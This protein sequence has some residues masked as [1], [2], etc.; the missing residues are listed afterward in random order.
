MNIYLL[1]LKEDLEPNGD[2]STKFF[3]TKILKA[4]IIA[5]EAGV[6]AC[7]KLI[8]ELLK[9]YKEFSKKT[10]VEEIKFFKKDGEDFSDGEILVEIIAPSDALLICERSILNFLQRTC[11]IATSTKK[12]VE[13]IQTSKCQILDTRKTAPGLR[14]LEKLA[15]KQA[16]GT[17]HR[18]NLSDAAMLK[19]NHLSLLGEDL[20]VAIKKLK[21][22]KCKIIVEINKNNLHK[23]EE[24]CKETVEQIMLDNFSVDE[25]SPI[26]EKIRH[27]NKAIKI[28]ASGGIN[29]NNIADYA[30][31]DLDYVSSAAASR[32]KNI[33]LSMLML[34]A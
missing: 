27:L 11:A 18:F 33:D 6:F 10:F 1:A 25:L 15:F 31:L 21:K 7:S 30:K 34:K 3:D 19:E 23:L 32:A 5:K 28:E 24:I 9:T 16:G 22:E 17:N 8:A 14:S 29:L 12:L 13:K 2:L 4:Q 26:I 20:L